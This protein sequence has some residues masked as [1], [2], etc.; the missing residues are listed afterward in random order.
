MAMRYDS[1]CAGATL[2]DLFRIHAGTPSESKKS[3]HR[4]TE[5]VGT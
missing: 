1:A 2:S 5:S 3:R 4:V